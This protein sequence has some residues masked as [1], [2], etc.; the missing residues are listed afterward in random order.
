MLS[1]PPDTELTVNGY[2]QLLDE[3]FRE[4]H[5]W[6]HE[7]LGAVQQRQKNKFFKRTYGKPYQKDDKVW[8]FSPQLAESKK[9][10]LP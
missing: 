8:L 6:A 10:Y 7:T 5:L 3:L 4:D 1:K 2:T 9:L